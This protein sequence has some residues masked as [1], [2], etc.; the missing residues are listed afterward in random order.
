MWQ[1]LTSAHFKN[2]I[3]F[4]EDYL[5]FPNIYQKKSNIFNN[6]VLYSLF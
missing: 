4:N 5:K 2:K 1:S 6:A 3:Q